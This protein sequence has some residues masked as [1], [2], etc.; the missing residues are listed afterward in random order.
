MGCVWDSGTATL[1][2][3]VVRV[4]ALIVSGQDIL[5]DGV[6][7]A[8]PGATTAT[9]DL[10]VV[11]GTAFDDQ[12]ALN[13][14]GGLFAPGAE[15]E[16]TGVSEIEFVFELG[17]NGGRPDQVYIEGTAGPDLYGL[18]VGGANLNADDDVDATFGGVEEIWILGHEGA[19][20]VAADGDAV[21]GGAL[22][23]LLAVLA[24]EDND[25]ITGGDGNDFLL[26]DQGAD[27]VSGVGGADSLN[28]GPGPD[29]LSGGTGIDTATYDNVQ[30]GGVSVN[31]TTE[32]ASGGGGADILSGIENVLGSISDDTLVGNQLANKLIGSAGN[33]LI[34]G[35]GGP[36]DLNG[37]AGNDLLRGLDG[38]DD[39]GGGAGNDRIMPGPGSDVA[40]GYKGR[41][42][43][44]LSTATRSVAINLSTGKTAGDGP[45]NVAGFER[46]R[47]SS[48]ADNIVGNAGANVLKG[49][50]GGGDTINGLG[51][52]DS[53]VGGTG[54]DRL[55]GGDGPDRLSGG[56]AHDVLSGGIGDDS[57]NARGWPGPVARGRRE[58]LSQ[59]RPRC[60]HL[61]SRRGHRAEDLLREAG[62]PRAAVAV[63]GAA[64]PVTRR[65][66]RSAVRL[67]LCGGAVTGLRTRGRGKP[68]GLSQR[69]FSPQRPR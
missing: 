68:V 42:T 1:T 63:A 9:V 58:R 13:L 20:V 17:G 54:E 39:I 62:T 67:G 33:D 46:G 32:S 18:G 44:D 3:T 66:C 49:G 19:D 14:F 4:G 45:D 38:P 26:G 31:L 6:A 10:S 55:L 36:D 27:A 51:G 15:V 7:C 16:P 60:G 61:L 5:F 12:V 59:R 34:N 52:A 25:T 37:D 41:D 69:V 24:G 57:L 56:A 29:E 28:G 64:H 22:P 11:N 48:F 2:V 40:R 8:P 30:L 65:A 35:R 47:G 21:V 50:R 23:I 53:L 43:L